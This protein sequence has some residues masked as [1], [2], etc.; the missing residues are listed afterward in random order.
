MTT[1]KTADLDVCVVDDAYCAGVTEDGENFIATVYRVVAEDATG[2]RW[3]HEAS[4]RGTKRVV[5]E[6]GIDHFPDLRAAAL[7]A[8][9][10]LCARV[11]AAATINLDHWRSTRPCYGSAAYVSEGQE[12]VDVHFER[13]DARI[14]G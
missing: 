12:A 4:F 14:Y 10:R 9:E 1:L 3:V 13:E 5:D 11:T 2:A 8:A 7:A 6:D